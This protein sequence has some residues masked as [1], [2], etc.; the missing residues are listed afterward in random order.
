VAADKET[1][2]CTLMTTPRAFVSSEGFLLRTLRENCPLTSFHGEWGHKYTDSR[3]SSEITPDRVSVAADKEIS[4]C[5]LMTTLRAFVNS[6]GFLLRTLRENCPLISFPSEWG[7]I[8]TSLQSLCGIERSQSEV[9]G[10]STKA[11]NY[12][13][14]TFRVSVTAFF[15]NPVKRVGVIV[16]QLLMLLCHLKKKTLDVD[17][18]VFHFH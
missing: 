9:V 2:R 4:R 17:V 3:H 11:L 18:R 14:H 16:Q 5:T 1:S 12:S 10:C 7:H 13:F 6:E 8:Q 15:P